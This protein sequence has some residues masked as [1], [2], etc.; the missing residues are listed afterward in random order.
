E[1]FGGTF[2]DMTR[3]AGLN[4]EMWSEIF[5]ENRNNL[6]GELKAL[7]LRLSRYVDALEEG[8]APALLGLLREGSE[9]RRKVSATGGVK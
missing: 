4:E 2:R 3:V 7:V 5:L 8:S 1:F 6:A 9:Y